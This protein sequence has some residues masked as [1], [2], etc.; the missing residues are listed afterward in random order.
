M[1]TPPLIGKMAPAVL[2]RLS[3]LFSEAA[4]AF[5]AMQHEV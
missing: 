1:E 4:R 5:D 2:R 3:R